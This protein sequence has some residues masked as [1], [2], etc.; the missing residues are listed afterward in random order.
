MRATVEAIA[1]RSEV[2]RTLRDEGAIEIVGGMYD[3]TNG[4]VEF[5]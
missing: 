1:E 4:E 2:L 3:V 5:F